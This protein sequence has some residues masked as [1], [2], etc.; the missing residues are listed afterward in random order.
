MNDPTSLDS[1]FKEKI[2]RIPDYQRGY[3]WQKNQLKDFWEDLINLS[4]NRSHYTGVLT[5]KQFSSDE[6]KK[7]DNEYWLVEDHSYN[8]YHVV[9]GQQRLTTFVL[10]LQAF[11]DVVKELEEN[12]GKQ[13]KDIYISDS[14]NLEEVTNRY[15][16]KSKPNGDLYRSYKFG[17]SID[18]PSYYYLRYEIFN[19][20]GAPSIEET[21]YTLNLRNAKRY[22]YEQLQVFNISGLQEIYKKFTKRFLFNE[23]VIKDEFDVFVAFETMNNRGKRL[24]DLELLKNRLIYLTTLYT[25]DELDSAGRSNLRAAIN[26]AWKEVYHQLGRNDKHPLND[27][28]FLKAHWIMY[29][30]YSRKRGN[31][32][33]TF[34]LDEQFSPKNILKKIEREVALEL[35]E[36]QLTDIEINNSDFELGDDEDS[37]SLESEYV[38]F[39]NDN[40]KGGTVG[41][42]YL[43]AITM[44]EEHIN[45]QILDAY[46]LK[47]LEGLKKRLSANGD[48]SGFNGERKGAPSAAIAKLIEFDL[49][50]GQEILTEGQNTVAYLQPEEIKQYVNSLKESA[51]HWF[52]SYYPYLATGLSDDEK[53]AI[54]RLNRIGMVYF[55]PLLMS[56][57]KTEKDAQKRID[58]LNHIERFI[59]ISFRLGQA[60]SNF[61]SSEFYN[62]SRKFNRGKLSLDE[63]QQMLNEATTYCVPEGETLDST[64][65]SVFLKKQFNSGN[66]NGYYDWNSL[67]Y[68]LYEYE[69]DL[70]SQNRQKRVLW[71]NLLEYSKY[72]VSIEHIFP[73]KPTEYWRQAFAGV[74]EQ[75]CNLYSG[76]VGN[77]LVLSMSIN[78]SLQNNDFNDKKNPKFDNAG[79]KIRN[80]YSDGSHSEIEVARDENWTPREIEE[81]GMKL[82]SFMEKRWR[83]KFKDE[84][85]KKDLLF[86]PIDDSERDRD[87]PFPSN[88]KQAKGTIR[89]IPRHRLLS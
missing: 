67:R 53:N 81:R 83:F 49:K 20:D 82:L 42:T 3:A 38:A 85:T 52:N 1:L 31:D 23:Y 89:R 70:M 65:F 71:E 50:E 5:L 46:S 86:L 22:F 35:P 14:L 2:F 47:Q 41:N 24:S 87:K 6:I 84:Q 10:F 27:N 30:Q 13:N 54:D 40:T 77:L 7:S 11:I 37:T 18:N 68:F 21:F 39:V 72:K 60:R 45:E 44:L 43:N 55:R 34:L 78:A 80:G 62:A 57:F 58:I 73:Q 12:K 76:S 69:L 51:V 15:L 79:K 25:D 33:I 17:Y 28:D 4:D 19:E 48:L 56:V 36:E 59:F 16:F 74:N 29:F 61:R 64:Y 88:P 32:Y 75:D 26:D 63:I 9:D 66:K 8:M